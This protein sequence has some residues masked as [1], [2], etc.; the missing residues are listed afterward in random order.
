RLSTTV[1]TVWQYSD[2]KSGCQRFLICMLA[3]S[4]PP[5]SSFIASLFR[6]CRIFVGRRK[7]FTN[8]LWR[9]RNMP[10]FDASS[11]TTAA[12]E[13]LRSSRAGR[14]A[15][16]ARFAIA[17]AFGLV[18]AALLP[19]V[20]PGQSSYY[21]HTFFDNGPRDASYY[22]SAGKAVPPSALETRGNRLPLD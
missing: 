5:R 19:A 8:P 1:T 12:P 10:A 11:Q 6:L 3:W 13:R 17:T 7:M 14:R 9:N 16:T 2:V 18:V 22:Y 4:H 20:A 15:V 21:R